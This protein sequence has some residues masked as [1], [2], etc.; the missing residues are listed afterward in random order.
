[1]GE[2]KGKGAKGKGQR[3]KGKGKGA[4]G[5]GRRAKG[6][7]QRAKGLRAKSKENAL[8]VV[9]FRSALRPLP[10]ALCPTPFAHHSP[11]LP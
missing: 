1:M 11:L 7:E 8:T 9:V 2:G 5:K 4:K 6:K 10:C 3:A